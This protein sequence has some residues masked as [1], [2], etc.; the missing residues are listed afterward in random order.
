MPKKQA[1]RAAKKPAR[2]GKTKSAA[3]A[4]RSASKARTS[5]K[6]EKYEQSGAPWWKMHLPG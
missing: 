2:S 6:D 5:K 3:P 4:K 1:K